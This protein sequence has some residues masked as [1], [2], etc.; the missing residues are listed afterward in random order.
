MVLNSIGI[1]PGRQWRGV[2]RWYSDEMLECCTSLEQ[3]RTRGIDWDEF[4]CLAEC[5][6]LLPTAVRHDEASKDQFE[7]ALCRATTEPDT[8][9]VLSWSRKALGQTGV[10]HFSPVA[11]YHRERRMALVLDVARFKYPSYWASVDDLWYR[12]S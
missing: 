1:D 6:G 12:S 11:A 8:H 5:H 3:V 9:L 7:E 2:W 4:V 10:G